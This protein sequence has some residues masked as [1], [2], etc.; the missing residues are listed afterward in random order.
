MSKIETSA[1]GCLLGTAVGDAMGLPSEG[2]SRERQLKMY[3]DIGRHHFLCGKGMISDD[4]EHAC[5]VSQALVVS[6]GD[7]DSFVRDLAWRLRFWLMGLPAGVGY[8]TLRAILKLWLGFPWYRSGVFSAG[9][10]PAMRS[11][12]IGVCYGGQPQSMCGLVAAA[13]RITHTDPRAE[14]GALAV[15]LAAHLAAHGKVV[16]PGR[17]LDRLGLLLERGELFDLVQKAA[18]SAERGES[19]QY[20]AEQMGLKHGITGYICHTVPAVIHCWLKNQ[21]DYRGAITEMIRCGGDT[22][23]TAAILGGIVGAH[24]GKAGI[25]GE[26]LVHLSEWPMT[27]LWMEELGRTLAH[28]LGKVEPGSPLPLPVWGLALRN[29]VFLAAVLLHGFRRLLPPY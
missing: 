14:H 13:T 22:D 17:Y 6:G 5:M 23:T 7:I 12:I 26:W 20:F 27:V 4:T 16:E 2:L 29:L 8:A 25:P 9:N 11:P 19:T 21:S 24:V 15:A 1:I 28:S 10:G 18:L 3:P